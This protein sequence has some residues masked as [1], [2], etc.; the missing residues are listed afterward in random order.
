MPSDSNTT[1]DDLRLQVLA[2]NKAVLFS[3]LRAAGIAV[4]TIT[5]DGYGDSGQFEAPHALTA[6]NIEAPIPLDQLAIEVVAFGSD[7]PTIETVTTGEL[8]ERLAYEFLEAKHDGWENDDGGFG[9]FR[10]DV[11]SG[12]ITLDYDERYTETKNYTYEF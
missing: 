3:A 9:E 6:E 2:R 12:T 10:F 8:V 5:F 4:V 1:D 11:A 7:A